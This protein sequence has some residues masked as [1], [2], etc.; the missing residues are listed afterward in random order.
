MLYPYKFCYVVCNTVTVNLSLWNGQLYARA[1]SATEEGPTLPLD[2]SP[3]GLYSRPAWYG[4][5]KF[6]TL[7]GL[8]IR[9]LSPPACGET[10]PTALSRPFPTSYLK[11]IKLRGRGWQYILMRHICIASV[12]NLIRMLSKLWCGCYDNFHFG[13]WS[14]VFPS[15][16][17]RVTRN[18]RCSV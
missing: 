14:S 5:R 11:S 7:L 12:V 1:A 9:P 3:S 8:D 6:L 18:S 16:R 17:L 2:R 15:W 4:K 13:N 10:I